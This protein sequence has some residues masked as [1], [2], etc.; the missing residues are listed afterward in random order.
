MDSLFS[1]ISRILLGALFIVFGV[2]KFAH[3]MPMPPMPEGATHLIIALVKAGY[4]FPVLGV[5]Y[6]ISGL[7][8]V[9]NKAVPFALILL[10]PLVVN[11]FLFHATLAPY[12]LMGPA[13]IVT[14]LLLVNI[15]S[16]RS[17]FKSLF[18]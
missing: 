3:F 4:F 12:G 15:A 9:A 17:R 18:Q 10:A 5:L 11:I 1:K 8:L 7:L 6:I 2:N 14:V 13:G 16:N